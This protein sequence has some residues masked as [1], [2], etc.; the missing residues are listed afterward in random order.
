M[1]AHGSDAAAADTYEYEE[2]QERETM[3]RISFLP[4]KRWYL[5]SPDVAAKFGSFPVFWQDLKSWAPYRDVNRLYLRATDG[6]SKGDDAAPAA[7][8]VANEADGKVKTRK[9]RWGDADPT[10]A[11]TPAETPAPKRR[12]RWDP[13]EGENEAPKKKSRW[14]PAGAAGADPSTYLTTEEQQSIVLR[15]KLDDLA[16]KMAT[17][18][19]D[20]AIIEK[21]PSRSPSPP[22]QYDSNGKR[23]NTREMR[24]RA[25]YERDR[26]RVMDQLVKV[27]PLFKPPPEYLKMKLQRKLPIPYKEYPTYNFMGLIIGPRGHTQKRMEKEYNCRIAIRGRGSG[28]EG[29]KSYHNDENEDLHVFITGDKEEDVERAAVAIAALLVP[30]D[31][32]T[33]DHKQRQLREL[34]RIQGTLRDDDYCLACGEQGHR[35]FECP[36][37]DKSFK[38]VNVKCSICGDTS[39]PTSDCTMKETDKAV[40][41]AEFSNFME[42][43]GEN[44]NIISHN[45]IKIVP[46]KSAPIPAAMQAAANANAPVGS[47][48]ENAYPVPS[49]APA[50]PASYGAA[51]TWDAQQQW[52]QYYASY[53]AAG[54]SYHNGVWYD[55]TGAAQTAYKTPT[56]SAKTDAA[57]KE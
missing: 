31:D 10:P 35:Q 8:A 30:V 39:H 24:M 32:M 49:A 7:P 4:M 57:K 42:Q 33:N 41:D 40:Y 47:S 56:L 3:M 37:R 43:L 15:A 17:V 23:L 52:Q 53:Y 26:M 44:G 27:N 36:N 34:A 51:Y 28:K 48:A 11:E 19:Y 12:S 1:A 54:W 13:I 20:A 5:S 46:D 50:Y 21:D 22:P 38:A 2:Q 55:S 45:T 29:R 6:S 25:M 16:R 9:S 14:A 18:A